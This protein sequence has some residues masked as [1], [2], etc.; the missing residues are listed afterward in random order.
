MERHLRMMLFPLFLASEQEIS[1]KYLPIP[2]AD[3]CYRSC[4]LRHSQQ[5]LDNGQDNRNITQDILLERKQ[6]YI[7]LSQKQLPIR[8]ENQ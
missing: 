7:R 2:A 4:F 5:T 1:P 6:Q 8:P 3:R